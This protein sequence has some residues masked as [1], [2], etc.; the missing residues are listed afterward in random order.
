MP[1]VLF[2][3]NCLNS[4]KE[5]FLSFYDSVIRKKI[6]YVPVV[7]LLQCKQRMNTVFVVFG[8]SKP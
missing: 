5:T 1:N 6:T 8:L 4:N 2:H 7:S 3:P